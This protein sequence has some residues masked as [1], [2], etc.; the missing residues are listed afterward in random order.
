M[1]KRNIS[2][3]HLLKEQK[4]NSF[5]YLKGR[6]QFNIRLAPSK[7][8]SIPRLSYILNTEECM[9]GTPCLWTLEAIV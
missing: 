3:N 5:K 4:V 6:H 8:L 2:Q 1:K 9:F 7:N